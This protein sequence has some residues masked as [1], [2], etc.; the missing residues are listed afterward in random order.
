MT[1][2]DI[3]TDLDGWGLLDCESNTLRARLAS[4][5]VS[6]DSEIM[7]QPHPNRAELEKLRADTKLQLETE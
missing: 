1:L 7:V 2:N 5:N 4:L 3:L 6:P